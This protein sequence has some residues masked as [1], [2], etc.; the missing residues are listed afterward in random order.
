MRSRFI[1]SYAPS[2]TQRTSRWCS[3]VYQTRFYR[4]LINRAAELQRAA[5]FYTP[6]MFI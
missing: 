6:A 4:M 2:R 3:V 1:W 5:I